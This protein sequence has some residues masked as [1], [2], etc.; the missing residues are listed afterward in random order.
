MTDDRLFIG[1][2]LIVLGV[3]FIVV[4]PTGLMLGCWTR[5]PD[6]LSDQRRAS[7]VFV[8]VVGIALGGWAFRFVYALSDSGSH[9]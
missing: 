7:G 8:G 4:M 6:L 1:L 5:A 2:F 9:A 3:I